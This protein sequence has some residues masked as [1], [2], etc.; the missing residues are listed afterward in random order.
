MKLWTKEERVALGVSDKEFAL[1]EVL[2]K[3]GAQNTSALSYSSSL[4][5]VTTI[6]ILKTLKERGFVTRHTRSREVVWSAV[7]SRV[8]EKRFGTLFADGVDTQK[9][10][11]LSEVGS[12]VVYRGID[13]ILESNQKILNT[14]KGERLLAIEPNGIWKHVSG[15]QQEVITHMNRRFKEKQIL[16]EMVVEE[17][18]EKA[19]AESIDPQ[20]AETFLALAVDVRVV[21][22]R[23]L[24]SS[25]EILMF[26]DQILFVDWANLVAIEIKDPSTARIMR[27]MYRL[28][29]ESGRP[30]K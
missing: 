5:R 22:A 8:L 10:T 17:G 26:R 6:R 13:A 1:L 2:H 19:I 9:T 15:T 23:F 7:D 18:F 30:V 21:P 27:T 20:L 11:E 12:L 4:P 3:E 16:I 29:Q 24:D 28:L 25:T 14:H